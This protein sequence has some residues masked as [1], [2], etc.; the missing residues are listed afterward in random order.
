MSIV[1]YHSGPQTY[2][3][4]MHK[5]KSDLAHEVLSLFD[6]LE[7]KDRRMKELSNAV[8]HL[9]GYVP[10]VAETIPEIKD[11]LDRIKDLLK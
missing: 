8:I 3:R 7:A 4:L 9:L 5:S 6:F 10:S 11:K 2:P 1:E